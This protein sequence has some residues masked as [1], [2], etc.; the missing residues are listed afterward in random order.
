MKNPTAT[1]NEMR[2]FIVWGPDEALA[3]QDESRLSV[4]WASVAS[5][6]LAWMRAGS[7]T[8]LDPERT[9][10]LIQSFVATM[11]ETGWNPYRP[12]TSSEPLTFGLLREGELV[13]VVA[14]AQPDQ[15][16]LLRFE[17]SNAARN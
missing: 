11:E 4:A 1:T 8:D 12:E 6:L 10:F 5:D 3:A 13:E 15:P 7:P 9:N 17:R 16:Q 2:P 14:H